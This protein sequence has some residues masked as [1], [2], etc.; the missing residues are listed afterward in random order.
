MAMKKTIILLLIMLTV[1]DAGYARDSVTEI[2]NL[3]TFQTSGAG[4]LLLEVGHRYLDVNR[5]TTNVY[6]ST[7]YGIINSV[8]VYA[9]YSFKNKDIVLSGK[10]NPLSDFG[11]GSDPVS[12]SIFAGAGYKD[13]NEINNSISLSYVESGERPSKT[14]LEAKDRPSFFIQ[15]II[16][17]HL[18]N[19]RL[20]IGLVPTFAW[21]TNFYRIPGE[22]DYTF[23]SGLFTEFYVT[24][25][26]SICGEMIMN[27]YGFAF[28]YMNYGAG[29][30]Y[31]GYRHTFS[32]WLGN[33]AGYSPV[34]YIVGNTILK[35]KIGF[36][37]TREF[38]L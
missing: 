2:F 11:S 8:D 7:G 14:V 17:K 16:E 13:T 9:G 28:K 23:G 5:H 32:F 21:N 15:P 31:A 27:I 1:A 20:G 4:I 22:K 30:K 34:E 25:R 36:S 19:N 12:F 29:V 38:D 33:S 3:P 37:F 35:P 24:D 6:I 18:F 10:Y 26:I